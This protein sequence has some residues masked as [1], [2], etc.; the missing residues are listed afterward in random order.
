MSDTLEDE[1]PE[2]APH[3]R[4]AVEQH[5]EAWVLDNYYTKLSPLGRLM[6]M[7]DKDELPSYDEDEHDT[8]SEEEQRE[9]A[10]ALAEYRENLRAGTKPG[11]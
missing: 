3:I 6:T 7:P 1:Y 11:E 5:G 9:M 4:R 2:A 10:R 8:M